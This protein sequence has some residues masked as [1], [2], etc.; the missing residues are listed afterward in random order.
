MTLEELQRIKQWQ[1]DAFRR[2]DLIPRIQ[3]QGQRCFPWRCCS[4]EHGLPD[5]VA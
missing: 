3:W 2:F 1:I 4:L 5:D